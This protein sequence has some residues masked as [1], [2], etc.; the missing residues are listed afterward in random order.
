M[1]DIIN[2][3]SVVWGALPLS[4]RAVLSKSDKI[5]IFKKNG[6]KRIMR[7]IDFKD[8]RTYKGECRVDVACDDALKVLQPWSLETVKYN[9]L[10]LTRRDLSLSLTWIN[11]DKLGGWRV[12]GNGITRKYSYQELA[13]HFITADGRNCGVWA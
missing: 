4:I 7:P 1:I 9:R 3:E 12:D 10:L 13:D 6:W 2:E 8:H 11:F 5:Y